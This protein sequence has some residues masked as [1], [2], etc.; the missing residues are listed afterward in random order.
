MQ[1]SIKTIIHIACSFLLLVLSEHPSFS[2]MSI[3][4][5]ALSGDMVVE[6][7]YQAGTG[8]P[9]GKI[10]SVRGKATIFHRDPA[11]GYRAKTGLPLYQGD[12]VRTL[13]E[14]RILYRL[15]DGSKIVLAPETTLLII[16][17]TY[18]STK[19]TSSSFLSLKRGGARIRVP[20][21]AELSS[22]SF[23]VQTESVFI[24]TKEADFIVKADLDKTVVIAFKE[25]RLE[26]VNMA[27]PEEMI[28]LS[29]FQRTIVKD[30]MDSPEVETISQEEAEA[31]TAEFRLLPESKLYASSAEK[32]GS[33]NKAEDAIEPG[34]DAGEQ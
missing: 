6:E 18:N 8:L 33:D 7:L 9:V 13:A 20:E 32:Y 27:D 11:V 25:S 23:K 24:D 21:S 34:D 19:K 2:E 28:F 12:T 15:V 17:S 3:S 5:R 14:A 1:T 4:E 31:L 29:D 30:E 26:V 22:S 10:Q 16:R